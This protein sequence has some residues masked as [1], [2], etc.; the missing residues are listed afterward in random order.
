[1]TD[2]QLSDMNYEEDLKEALDNSYSIWSAQDAAR[3]ASN[4][5][6][7]GESSTVDAYEAAKLNL[8][9]AKESAENTFRQL[10]RD[11]QD[12]KRLLDEA[13]AAYDTEKREFR[14]GCAAI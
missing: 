7:D 12:K 4:Q 8:D 13:K 11:V 1:M 3:E 2:A 5:Y 14:C 6:E 9:Y 10:H